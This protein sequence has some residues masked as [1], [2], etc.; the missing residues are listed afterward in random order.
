MSL[1]SVQSQLLAPFRSMI[2]AQDEY[3]KRTVEWL[4]CVSYQDDTRFLSEKLNDNVPGMLYVATPRSEHS[5][6]NL[7]RILRRSVL[8]VSAPGPGSDLCGRQQKT[9]ELA[10]VIPPWPFTMQATNHPPGSRSPH[11]RHWRR[12]FKPVFNYSRDS[13]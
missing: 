9:C 2:P 4:T 13:G 1:M 3:L 10:L 8:P 7:C 5:L 11:F 12:F 6:T